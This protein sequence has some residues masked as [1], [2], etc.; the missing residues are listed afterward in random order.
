MKKD[1]AGKLGT[2]IVRVVVIMVLLLGLT[3][4]TFSFFSFRKTF[5]N[6]YSNKAENSARMI[7]DMID[8]DR[9]GDYAHTLEKDA[10]YE[11]LEELF[12]ALKR[13]S[14]ASYLYMFY[15]EEDSFIYILD[16]Y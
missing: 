9:M 12:S 14:G 1:R 7:A 5:R 10:Y 4:V 16:A 8:G 2:K 3:L 13:D 6:V 15:P 11:E